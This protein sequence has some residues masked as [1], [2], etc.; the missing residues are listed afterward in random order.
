[1]KKDDSIEKY[2]K[3]VEKGKLEEDIRKKLEKATKK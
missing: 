2:E 1:L 3:L